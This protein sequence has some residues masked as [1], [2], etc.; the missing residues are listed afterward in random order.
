M[1]FTLS[2]AINITIRLKTSFD[3]EGIKKDRASSI[4]SLRA[5]VSPIPVKIRGYFFRSLNENI[6][7]K[8]N[9]EKSKM[10]RRKMKRGERETEKKRKRE[11]QED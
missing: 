4:S 11:E 10:G 7:D 8:N 2:R 3:K 1:I 6:L 9:N 5:L